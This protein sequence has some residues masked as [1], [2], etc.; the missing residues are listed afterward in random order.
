MILQMP[1]LFGVVDE[2]HRRMQA[3]RLPHALL[4]RGREGDGAAILAESLAAAALCAMPE[5]GFACGHCKSC[6]LVKAQSHPDLVRLEPTGEMNRIQIDSVRTLVDRFATTAQI[7][8]R[9][10]ALVLRADS[11]NTASANALL[12]TLEEPA[13]DSLIILFSEGQRPLLPTIRSRCQLFPVPRPSAAQVATWLQERH[14]QMPDDMQLLAAAGGEPLVLAQLLEEGQQTDWRKYFSLMEQLAAQNLAPVSAVD[15]MQKSRVTPLQQVDWLM[16]EMA[17]RSCASIE[18]GG[19][20]P[21]ETGRLWD[22][23]LAIRGEILSGIK[24]NSNALQENL[25]MLWIQFNR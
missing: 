6:E 18:Q 4:L 13:G 24:T 17:R 1:W 16:A 14:L 5:L 11:M 2:F 25:A 8:K 12:K 7:A 10:V 15:Q 19:Q 3:G 23:C 20:P 22:Q 9:K 21:A